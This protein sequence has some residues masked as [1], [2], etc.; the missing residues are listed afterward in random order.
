MLLDRL[1][2]THWANFTW[3]NVKTPIWQPWAGPEP[4]KP[5]SQVRRAPVY[6]SS[7]MILGSE[8][9]L[10]WINSAHV[11]GTRSKISLLSCNDVLLESK[12]DSWRLV[13]LQEWCVI[14]I[15][16]RKLDFNAESWKLRG[17]GERKRR[18]TQRGENEERQR[19]EENRERREGEEERDIC[20]WLLTWEKDFGCFSSPVSNECVFK[21]NACLVKGCQIHSFSAIYYCHYYIIKL[22]L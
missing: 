4:F 8:S 18:R 12:L 14:E 20:T 1:L 16:C 13:I 11:M 2:S 22:L 21:K 17:E 19:R 5:A 6:A 9:G 15:K 10:C 3:V 7:R